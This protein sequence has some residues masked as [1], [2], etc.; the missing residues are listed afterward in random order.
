MHSVYLVRHGKS[1]LDG[2]EAERGL[3]PEGKV[4]AQ[5]IADFL[6]TQMPSVRAIYCSPYMRA[7]LTMEPLAGRLG[8]SIATV[9]DFREKE[10]SDQ[11]IDDLRGGRIRMWEDFNFR[12]PGGET[13]AEAQRRAVDALAQI[14][15]AHPDDAVAIGSHGT[16]IGLMINAFQASFGYEDWRSMPMPDI[17]RVNFSQAGDPVIDH[18]GC[19]NADGFKIK[20]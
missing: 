16:L 5:E 12:L 8:L 19:P 3:E 10:M 18:I 20:D 15:A 6:L 7:R 11:P 2:A 1:S 9:N 4:H 14:R 13:N 17:F